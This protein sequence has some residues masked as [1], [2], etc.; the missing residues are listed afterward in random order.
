MEVINKGL[1]NVKFLE[2]DVG[3]STFYNI[4]SQDNVYIGDVDAN[5][6]QTA[7]FNIFINKIALRNVN[8]PVTVLYK[9]TNNKQYTKNYII[10]SISNIKKM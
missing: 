10:N 2:I 6:F 9:D 5:D 7:D 3:S 4:I 8:L 1:A